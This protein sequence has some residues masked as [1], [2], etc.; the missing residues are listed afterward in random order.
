[1][2]GGSASLQLKDSSRDS[3]P[4]AI[5]GRNLM[6]KPGCGSATNQMNQTRRTFIS[7]AVG[8]AAIAVLPTIAVS[9]CRTCDSEPPGGVHLIDTSRPLR[10]RERERTVC[11][12][13]VPEATIILRYSSDWAMRMA[14][15]MGKVK[16]KCSRCGE[17]AGIIHERGTPWDRRLCVGCVPEAAD[18]R[19]WVRDLARSGAAN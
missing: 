19:R 18:C 17:G 12:T 10:S 14:A 4:G 16:I 1:V 11:F 3:N 9:R 15:T 6:E 5:R 8:A 13:C 7:T 2:C